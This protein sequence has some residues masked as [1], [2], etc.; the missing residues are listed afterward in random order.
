MSYPSHEIDDC[1]PTVATLPENLRELQKI[2][3][4]YIGKSSIN[5]KWP[6]SS[7][8]FKII[9]HNC[10]KSSINGH[11]QW[12]NSQLRQELFWRLKIFQRRPSRWRRTVTGNHGNGGSHGESW[13]ANIY[14]HI[15]IYPYHE[16]PGY[17]YIYIYM[18][19]T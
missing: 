12:L 19:D 18:W 2:G 15:I 16:R 3:N 11:V 7:I 4:S 5:H 1:W 10:R 8:S 13:L 17:A 14:C 9:S 6:Y